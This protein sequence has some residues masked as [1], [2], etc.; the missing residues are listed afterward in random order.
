MITNKRCCCA[1]IGPLI[2]SSFKH[3]QS[4][5]IA[6]RLEPL[7]SRQYGTLLNPE[8]I[9]SIKELVKRA[10]QKTKTGNRITNKAGA[11]YES[12]K[13]GLTTNL[14]MR[15]LGLSRQQIYEDLQGSKDAQQPTTTT[16]TT[17]TTRHARSSSDS[18]VHVASA[19]GYFPTTS[20]DGYLQPPV[21]AP[22]PNNGRFSEG[23]KRLRMLNTRGRV[24][25]CLQSNDLENRYWSAF[26]AHL[27]YWKVCF[28][29]ES[30]C[31]SKRCADIDLFIVSKDAD[32]AAFL[33]KE[34]Y[35]EYE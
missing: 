9:P 32:V 28:T 22:S 13:I 29:N 27:Q 12:F 21:A 30:N 25:Y 4:D 34:I 3:K 11:M 35:K 18:A 7:I 1:K 31:E 17:M 20:N 14:V 8:P 2:V 19:K 23:A 15:G 33:I 10:K 5:P 6:Y 26:S 24:D 16:T